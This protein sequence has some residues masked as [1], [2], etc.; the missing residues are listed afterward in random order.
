ME[1][2]VVVSVYR[3]RQERVGGVRCE[4]GGGRG[5]SGRE[6]SGVDL[7]RAEAVI[8]GGDVTKVR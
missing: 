1:E 3:R 6:G 5:G 8:G 2:D 7:S 4:V